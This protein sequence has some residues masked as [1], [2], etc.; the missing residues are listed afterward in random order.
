MKNS[1]QNVLKNLRIKLKLTIITIIKIKI[2]KSNKLK[3]QI[4][5]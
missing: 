4:T 5:N 1:N 2:N 3:Y